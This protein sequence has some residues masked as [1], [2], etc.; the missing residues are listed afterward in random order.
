MEAKSECET[1]RFGHPSLVGSVLSVSNRHTLSHWP[2]F[3][4][5]LY[6]LQQPFLILFRYCFEY[7][8]STRRLCWNHL[9]ESCSCI[10]FLLVCF[11]LIFNIERPWHCPGSYRKRAVRLRRALCHVQGPSR[12][13]H[14]PERSYICLRAWPPVPYL[15]R[16]PK[17]FTSCSRREI[18]SWERRWFL[19]YQNYSCRGK[20]GHN[21]QDLR[22]RWRN[23]PERDPAY[24][25]IYV[26][27][28]GKPG[29]G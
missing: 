18:R 1:Y 24:L 21:H 10:E 25:D 2:T 19:T 5:R 3:V 22:R 13:A 4:F 14:L 6:S 27:N 16:A 7:T 9:Y 23:S 26:Y 28:N 11:W 8:T 20:G 12:S 17:K 15:F 29:V